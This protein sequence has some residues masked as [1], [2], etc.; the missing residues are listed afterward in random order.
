[1]SIVGRYF[2]P[3][4]VAQSAEH[5]TRNEDVR[6]S[7]PRGGSNPMLCG[8]AAD[9]KRLAPDMPKCAGLQAALSGDP[10]MESIRDYFECDECGN[11]HFKLVYT[12]SLRFHGVNFSDH[13]IYDRLK[14]E[15][16]QCTQCQKTFSDAEIEEGL[17]RIRNTRMRR[18]S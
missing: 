10:R 8:S 2:F 3:A 9:F 15:S 4:T 7:I 12:F 6:G 1:M 16:Y 18:S 11:M 5:L 13:L 17:C 14:E